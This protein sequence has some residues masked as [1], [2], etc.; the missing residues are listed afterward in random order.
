MHEGA[1]RE[2]VSAMYDRRV[3]AFMKINELAIGKA[4]QVENYPPVLGRHLLKLLSESRRPACSY[5]K[6]AAA[7]VSASLKL[8]DE[9]GRVFVRA[10]SSGGQEEMLIP[11]DAV[12]SA[13]T[14][15]WAG[16]FTSRVTR[17][18]QHQ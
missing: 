5:D 13:D 4:S 16:W 7:G 18:W 3:G 2:E 1:T 8:A 10:N 17:M 15:P 12:S 11:P 6:Q 9:P 14:V